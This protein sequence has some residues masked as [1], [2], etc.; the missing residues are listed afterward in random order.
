MKNRP[1]YPNFFGFR[2]LKQTYILFWPK[3]ILQNIGTIQAKN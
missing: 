1:T 3:V 2:N